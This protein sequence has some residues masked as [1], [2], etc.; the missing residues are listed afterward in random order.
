MAFKRARRIIK[1]DAGLL[2]PSMLDGLAI[3]QDLQVRVGSVHTRS[4]QVRRDE[5]CRLDDAPQRELRPALGHVKHR[6]GRV[7]D[8]KQ[9]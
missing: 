5:Q 8:L 6:A 9:R 4:A 3:Q 1:Q 2:S 7:A